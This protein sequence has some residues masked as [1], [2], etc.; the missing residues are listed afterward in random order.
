VWSTSTIHEINEVEDKSFIAMAYVDGPSLRDEVES[1]PLDVDRAVDIAIQVA[2]G[3][4]VAHKKGIIHRDIKSANIMLTS[5]GQAKITDFGLAKL[6]GRT[7]LTKTGTTVGTLA[8]MSPE[9]AQGAEVDHR[10]DIWSLGVVLYELLTGKV[11]FRGD[12]EAAMVYSIMNQDVEPPSNLTPEVP[13]ELDSIVAKTLQKNPDDRYATT[14]EFISDL[15]K[16][17]AGTAVKVA[18][19]MS[20]KAKRV[21]WGLSA[22]LVV[23]AV[24]SSLIILNRGPSTVV[25]R[26]LAVVDFDIIG[27]EDAPHLAKGIAEGI[28]SKMSK[29][30][31][32]RVS[33]SDDIRRLRQKDKSAKEVASQLG[34][35]FALCG[36]LLRTGGQIRV[37]PQLIDASTGDVIWSEPFDRKFSNVLD[38]LDEVSLKIVEVLKI[39]LEPGDRVALE[40]RPTENSEAYEHYLKGR[41]FY[42]RNTFRDNR[43]SA[44]EFQRALQIDP[45]YPFALAG[46]AD[47]YVQRYKERYDY[48][49]HWLDEADRL[50]DKALKL[51]QD[52]AEAYESKAEVLLEKA[53]YKA[54]LAAA[55]KARDIRPDWDEPYLRL[56]EIYQK[57]GEGSL[58]FQMFE[59]AQSMRPSVNA[60]VGRGEYFQTRR[61][62]KLAEEAYRSAIEQ[63][64]DHAGPYMLLSRLYLD[65]GKTAEGDS[66]LRYAIEVR[67]D[68]AANYYALVWHLWGKGQIEEAEKLAQ[69]FTEKH[70][71]NWEG[72]EQLFN[73]TAWGKGDYSAALAVAEEAVS[74]NSD[75]VW[76]YLLLASSY[77][78]GLAKKGERVK[79]VNAIEK[80]LELRPHSGRVLAQA[81]YLYSGFGERDKAAEFYRRALD[82]NPDSPDIL[83]A[84]GDRMLEQGQYDS[85][86]VLARKVVEQVPGRANLWEEDGYKQLANVLPH[87]G[88]IDELLTTIQNAADKYGQD[89]PVFYYKLGK[90]QCLAG[91]FEQ[92]ILTFQRFPEFESS[93]AVL[94]ELGM[95]QWLS[96]DLEAALDQE[97]WLYEK[98]LT[99]VL[100]YLARFEDIEKLY[101]DNRKSGKGHAWAWW[102]YVHYLTSM[103]RY[104]DATAVYAEVVESGKASYDEDYVIA[105]A[106]WCLEQGD[107]VKAR[108]TIADADTILTSGIRPYA[109]LVR[110]A[111]AC[112]EGDIRKA[113]RLAES[114]VENTGGHVDHD[115]N[116]AFLAL[117]Y[118]SSG[119]TEEALEVLR[120]ATAHRWGR[121]AALYYRAQFETLLGSPDAAD[122]MKRALLF[123]TRTAYGESFW[124]NLGEARCWC[125]LASGRLGDAQRARREI[126]YALQLEPE[127]ADIAYYAACAYSLV[128]D[129]Q[130][131]LDWLEK[132]V[133]RDH[134]GLWWARVDPDL[135]PLRELPRFQEIMDDWE[136]RIEA[137]IN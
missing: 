9:Q 85:S 121:L 4:R 120:A 50:I 119:R 38:F 105:K 109:D 125:A 71:Y 123:A 59:K 127:R 33:S 70:P 78:W 101:E 46:L 61:E 110:A 49:E 8:Y 1:G 3:L 114:V 134:Q 126:E 76:P 92:A 117:L 23:A 22:V 66:L 135:D 6:P 73:W 129:T 53:N 39:E 56:G 75:R 20:R 90:E 91:Q 36:S 88:R 132:V 103:R 108:Q 13:T 7:K 55:K 27:G 95:A 97:S 83:M 18:L 128:G 51:E 89:N 81:G 99:S 62:F 100:K 122:L 69:D 14:E 67:P 115:S 19:P 11:P 98:R 57:R 124:Y 64:P 104:E 102:I 118:Y 5:E 74:R 26:T 60:L 137:L 63:N 24:V 17:Q 68:H 25:A 54:A 32:V 58:A 40:E 37:T 112:T 133:E 65:S 111:I 72:Y 28:S 47:A 80:A 45:E 15:R 29:L 82:V 48:D 84:M 107:L 43:L 42:Y 31:S 131:A 16:V 41:H 130:K 116:R 34:A 94:G 93:I 87:L 12:H 136:R 21:A 96:G 77:Q 30:K 2:D 86:A 52:L 79:A 106:Y 35:E 113:T 44:K 10:T